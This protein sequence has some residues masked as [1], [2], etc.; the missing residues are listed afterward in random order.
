MIEPKTSN[1]EKTQLMEA[2]ERKSE[3]QFHEKQRFT[4]RWI[5]FLLLAINGLLVWG[6][7]QQLVLG[8]PFGDKPAGD[9][10]L[11]VVTLVT[12]GISLGMKTFCLETIILS[13][14]IYVRFSPFHRKMKYYPWEVVTQ[15]YVRTYS[16][17]LEYGG[18][19]FRIG[20]FGK[21]KAYNIVGDEGLQLT[22]A[23]K[24][25]LL[26]GTQRATELT[27]V[28]HRMGRWNP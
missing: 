26:I 16:P 5:F 14:G 12:L 11:V 28:L 13:D 24:R 23:D 4:Q 1:E 2:N 27:E 7:F 9:L 18:W 21:G 8:K 25:R 17:I 15:C 19:G 3:I 20:L 6:V 22:F 10:E